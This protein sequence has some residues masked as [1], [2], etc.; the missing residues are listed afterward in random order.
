MNQATIESLHGHLKETAPYVSDDVALD[1]VENTYQN[2]LTDL[3]ATGEP[4]S[5]VDIDGIVAKKVR[6]HIR[7]LD[8]FGGSD[9]GVLL[10]EFDGGYYPHET[11]AKDIVRQKLCLEP[12]GVSNGDMERGSTLEPFAEKKFLMGMANKGEDGSD[13][14]ILEK[15]PKL[16]DFLQEANTKDFWPEHPWVRSSPDG[17]Y[18]DQHGETWLVDF[19]CPALHDTV[20][21]IYTNP[22]THYRA[23]LAQYKMHLEQYGIQVD[24]VVICPFSTKEFKVYPAEFKVDAELVQKVKDAGDFYFD[25]VKKTELP[26]RPPGQDFHQIRQ[27]P[28]P[29]RDA[30]T[31][32]IYTKK[33]ESL[34]KNA[35]DKSKQ[36]LLDLASVCGVDWDHDGR[37]VRLPGVDISQKHVERFDTDSL[38]AEIRRLGGDPDDPK[39]KTSKAQT[40]IRVIQSK[41]VEHR[42]F[43]ESVQDIAEGQYD[44][45]M[46]DALAIFDEDP[47]LVGVADPI[48][49]NTTT[50][51]GT[52]SPEVSDDPEKE[53]DVEDEGLNFL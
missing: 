13:G 42:P 45:G 33:L 36:R 43:I 37:K 39:L 10:T 18:V 1:W 25:Y 38:V 47:S 9:M 29:L 14:I 17:L 7:R 32:Y 3:K 44:E 28:A 40:T 2:V 5:P 19:K 46:L 52:H 24:H 35:S 4:I 27:V 34:G 12:A 49:E 23:Q 21:D 15:H 51:P 50:R 41:K 30:I 6:W 20:M 48:L 11:S 53:P 26:F 22:P 16:N 31:K 8:G